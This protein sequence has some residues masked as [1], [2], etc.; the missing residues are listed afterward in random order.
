M[1]VMDDGQARVPLPARDPSRDPPA[2]AGPRPALPA[3]ISA[4]I[5][6]AVIHRVFEA[7]LALESAAGLLD[8][9][10]VALV[11]RILDDLDQLVRDIRT[12]MLRP[13]TLPRGTIPDPE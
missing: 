3:P 11:L 9:P 7:G 13:R 4:D 12:T 2:Q 10:M 5:A 8:G 1:A 6:A